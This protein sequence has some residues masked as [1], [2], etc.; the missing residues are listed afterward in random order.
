[1]SPL[2]TYYSEEIR[3]WLRH[4]DRAVSAFDV[5]ELFGKAYI[6]CQTAQISING[7]RVTGIYP[8]DRTKFTDNEFI[9][10]A[11]KMRKRNGE[12]LMDT[13]M[14]SQGSKDNQEIPEIDLNR[15]STSKPCI[16]PIP[17]ATFYGQ[18]QKK[19]PS[20][21]TESTQI[22]ASTFCHVSPF[23]IAPIPQVKKRFLREEE[24]HANLKS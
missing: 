5:M 1:M 18:S 8:I 2:K 15:P 7:F 23:D 17:S 21:T 13:S 4:N 3:Q 11:S 10:E 14:T 20:V 16:S 12:Q 6:K 22:G 24:R 9:E 19:F